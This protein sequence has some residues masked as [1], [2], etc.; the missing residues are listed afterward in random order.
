MN[1]SARLLRRAWNS[2]GVGR[3][4]R[5][6]SKIMDIDSQTGSSSESLTKQQKARWAIL[7]LILSLCNN[8]TSHLFFNGYVASLHLAFRMLHDPQLYKTGKRLVLFFPNFK[9]LFTR[10]LYGYVVN[11]QSSI[12]FREFTAAH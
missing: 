4:Y 7:C 8:L 6:I 10:S 2:L 1:H 9:D 12:A 5:A 11:A 3:L